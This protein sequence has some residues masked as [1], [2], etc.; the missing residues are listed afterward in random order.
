MKKTTIKIIFTCITVVLSL[1][2]GAC[3][4]KTKLEYLSSDPVIIHQSINF[5]ERELVLEKN[6]DVKS[7]L[8]ILIDRSGI[9]VK[10]K[11]INLDGNILYVNLSEDGYPFVALDETKNLKYVFET[12]NELQAYILS[13]ISKTVSEN[14][15]YETRFTKE[16]KDAKILIANIGKDYTF[17]PAEVF[18]EKDYE[19]KVTYALYNKDTSYTY[20]YDKDVY[21]LPYIELL[22]R[23]SD[24]LGEEF[25]VNDIYLE[26]E[27]LYID[28]TEISS[29]FNQNEY[30]TGVEQDKEFKD[31]QEAREFRTLNSIAKTFKL[32]YDIEEVYFL[33]NGESLKLGSVAFSKEFPWKEK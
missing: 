8:N 20:S 21:D 30:F 1:S 24:K 3:S 5:S 27:N 28:F 14:F 7:L 2:L 31:A 15:G 33:M 29:P 10:I 12:E 23:L 13:S 18:D 26:G 32:N 19:N 9:N 16:G 22:M 25:V 17:T 6:L 11:N 4:S